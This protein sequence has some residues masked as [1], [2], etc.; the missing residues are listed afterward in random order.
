M[1]SLVDPLQLQGALKSQPRKGLDATP[2]VDVLIILFLFA[3]NSSRFVLAPGMELDLV[4]AG[5]FTQTAQTPTAALTID[6]HGSIFFQGL[7]I[8]EERLGRS[9]ESYL[10]RHPEREPVLLVMAD[11]SMDLEDLFELMDQAR[12]AGFH[13]VHLAAEDIWSDSDPFAD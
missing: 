1:A 10:E 2:F 9:L 3:V 13:Q 6:R 12:R 4:Q 7:K 5:S 11:V 8:P